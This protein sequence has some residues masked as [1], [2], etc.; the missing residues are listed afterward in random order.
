M[1]YATHLALLLTTLPS[2]KREIGEQVQRM[3]DENRERLEAI[4]LEYVLSEITPESTY[5]FEQQIGTQSRELARQ[6]VERI[7]NRLEPDEHEQLPHD[8]KF[9]GGGYRRRNQKTRN[10]NVSTLFGTIE[11]HRYSYRYWHRDQGEAVIFPLELQLG[12]VHGATPA[13]AEAAARYTA[14]SGATQRVVLDRLKEQHGVR[15]GAQRLRNVTGDISLAME[16]FRQEYQI[17][18]ILELLEKA[19][20]STGSR[21][22]VLAAG[23]DGVTL[24]EYRFSFYEHATAGTVSVYDR[25]GQRLGTVYLAFVPE[26]GQGQ[27]T[28]QLTALVQ[29]TLRR[30]TGRLPRLCYVTDAGDNET[31]YYRLVLRNMRHPVTGQRLKWYR[32]VDYYHTAERI[33]SMADALFGKKRAQQARAWARRMCRLLKKPNGPSRVLHSAGALR[34]RRRLSQSRDEEFR[35]ASNYIRRRTRFM[36][37]HDYQQLQ[38]PIGSGVTEAACKTIFAQRLKLSGM[39][40]EKEGAQVILNL[41][42]SLLSNIW[43]PLY[44]RVLES[45]NSHQPQVYDIT[46]QN[47]TAV[48]A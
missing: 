3:L 44:H 12:L 10:K 18:K 21:K 46:S 27:M 31:K 29:E 5:D 4:T 34:A 22:P 16:Q 39:R 47:P 8:V 45:Y 30:W 36:Q 9:E 19:D 28:K 43:Q 20:K 42:V 11:L 6:L 35:K 25:R 2:I 17:Q 40:W 33:W 26:P 38:L 41:R 14:Q 23:R 1:S 48:A 15:W 24:R 13:L 32:I 7:Y 37:Y